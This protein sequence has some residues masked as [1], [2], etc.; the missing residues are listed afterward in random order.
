[1]KMYVNYY[2]EEIK[3]KNENKTIG[4]ILCKSKKDLLVKYTLD[5]TDKQIFV[6]KYKLYIPSEQDFQQ[7]FE[8]GMFEI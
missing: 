1:M 2:D 3:S 7:L 8:P 4:I 5:K 6:S